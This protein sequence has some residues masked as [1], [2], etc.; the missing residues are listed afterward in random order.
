MGLDE[1]VEL[2]EKITTQSDLTSHLQLTFKNKNSDFEVVR[3]N[4]VEKMMRDNRID[5]ETH[6][7]IHEYF[8]TKEFHEIWIR[9]W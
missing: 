9:D 3:G 1:V 6:P 2:E 5:Q 8:A 7:I 4:I